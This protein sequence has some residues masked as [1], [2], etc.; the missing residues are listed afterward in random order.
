[1]MK[2][3][4]FIAF[5]A[6]VVASPR[7][8]QVQK[9]LH[10]IA[11]SVKSSSEYGLEEKKEIL[12][13]LKEMNTE[14]KQF[15]SASSSRKTEIKH[16]LQQQLSQLKGSMHE[17]EPRHLEEDEDS[18][19][20][21]IDAVG[22]SLEEV[23][24]QVRSLPHHKAQQA[25]KLIHQLESQY[26]RLSPSSTKTARKEIAREMK[27]VVE[28][29]RHVM[30]EE[31][32][33]F[34]DEDEAKKQRVLE[35]ID[36]VESEISELPRHKQA[37]ARKILSSMKSDI[38]SGMDL[39]TL[40]TVLQDK[41]NQLEIISGEQS[42]SKVAKI[43]DDVAEVERSL[44]SEH[45]SASAKHAIR[46]SL[47]TIDRKAT[48]YE[49]ADAAEKKALQ[50]SMKREMQLIKSQYGHDEASFEEEDDE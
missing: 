13:T 15:D 6:F 33:N 45:L 1:M 42:D 35:D 43:H 38:S 26:A 20:R 28:E 8:L 32:N 19:Q 44:E 39:P 49:S 27:S 23:K 21:K 5:I 34:E 22:V 25:K 11:R 2:V 4:C 41:A 7:A 24:S 47:K 50:A 17:E 9:D 29:L 30:P 40:K 36:Q 14:A 31:S 16:E 10:E 3:V 12:E 48:A 37:E 46:A 18:V